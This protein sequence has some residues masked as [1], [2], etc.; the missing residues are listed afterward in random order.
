[1][2]VPQLYMQTQTPISH[3]GIHTPMLRHTHRNPCTR[4]HPPMHFY[5]FSFHMFKTN[6]KYLPYIA[7]RIKLDGQYT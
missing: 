5:Y 1:M 7:V 6:I 2:H 4:P 3:L